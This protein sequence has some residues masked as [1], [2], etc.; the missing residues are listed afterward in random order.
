MDIDRVMTFDTRGGNV[1]YVLKDTDV[2]ESTT[3]GDAI[4]K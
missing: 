1:R 4:G 3:F 2:N